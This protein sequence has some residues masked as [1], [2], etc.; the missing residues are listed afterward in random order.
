MPHTVGSLTELN[1]LDLTDRHCIIIGGLLTV[2]RLLIQSGESRIN[3]LTRTPLLIRDVTL[4]RRLD[5]KQSLPMKSL[6]VLPS[7][8]LNFRWHWS[9]LEPTKKEYI[10]SLVTKIILIFILL[11]TI[12]QCH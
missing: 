11:L 6:R 12:I 1:R 7:L 2:L 10:I 9:F 5:T 3:H 4:G 8:Y